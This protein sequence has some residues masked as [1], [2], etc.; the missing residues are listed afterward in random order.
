[1]GSHDRSTKFL[2]GLKPALAATVET[3]EVRPGGFKRSGTRDATASG[4]GEMQADG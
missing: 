3:Y 2:A 1:M 4:P